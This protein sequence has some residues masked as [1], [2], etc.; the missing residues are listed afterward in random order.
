MRITIAAVGRA[1]QDASADLTR[2]YLRRIRWP[3]SIKEVEERRNLAPAAL[4]A[5]EA[6]L[7]R[8]ALPRGATLV[9]LDE[10]GSQ[11]SSVEFAE[12]IGHWRDT[13]IA[14]LGF[15]I[16]G[17]G[18]LS[19]ELLAETDFRL[20]LGPMTWPHLLVRALLAEQL[21]RAQSILEGHPYHR[22]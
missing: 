19:Q 3:V 21:Y 11:L 8:A 7:L 14:D 2:A 6:E 12:K 15:L 13:G 10:R 4:I 20:S 1:R 9:S 16:G 5:R 17:A 22:A 18:G